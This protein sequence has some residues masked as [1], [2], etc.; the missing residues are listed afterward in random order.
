M[1]RRA[2]ELQEQL[3][4]WRRDFHMHPEL[5]FQEKRTA[6]KVAEVLSGL[7]WQV[8]TGVGRTGVTADLG[9]ATGACIAIRA[10]M[11]ALPMQEENPEIAYSSQVPGVMHACGHDAHTAIALGVATLLKDQEFTGRVRL[12]MQPSEEA[13]DEE[14]ISGAR[15]MIEDG[16]MEGVDM[17]IALHV[18]ARS[19]TGVIRIAPG[20]CSGGVDNF[21]ATIFGV[22]AHGASPQDGV[23]PFLISAQVIIALNAITSRR[24]HPLAE[25]VVS[26]GSLHGGQAANVIPE[27]IEL[28]GTLRYMKS[29]VQ[30]K[31]HKEIER[32]FQISQA[33]GGDYKLQFEIGDPP[34]INHPQA[35]ALIKQAADDLMGT[36]KVLQPIKGLGA[37]DF[38]RFSSLVPGAMFQLG[39]KID[40]DERSHHHPRFDIDE[41]CLPIGV[42]ILAESALR[43]LAEPMK[44][45]EK[46]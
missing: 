23:D 16:A 34:M 32:A 7:G 44:Y 29:E 18:D 21:Y 12:L 27:Q 36:G 6:S 14:G 20:P 2:N 13:G 19:Q 4:E 30:E 31:I 22:G 28:A 33:L 40:S 39:C 9:D 1:L 8:R 35:V 3:V 45:V 37:E 24:L 17:V 25:A 43:F 46:L 11:D 41:D 5:G 10:D 26:L 15:R 42:A 38:G